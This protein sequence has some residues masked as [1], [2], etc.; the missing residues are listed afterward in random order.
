M[1]VL[2]RL[3]PTRRKNGLQTSGRGIALIAALV[4]SGC[5]TNG[6]VPVVTE[7]DLQADATPATTD[8][9]VAVPPP[10]QDE[11]L[12]RIAESE[13]PK[14][15]KAY[16]G[17]YSDSKLERS[18]ARIVGALT[19]V[20]DN[21]TQSYRITILDSPNINAFALPG[22]YVYVTRGLLALANDSAELAAVISHEMAHVTA[23]H[24]IQRQQK[25]AQ[26]DLGSRVASQVLGDNPTARAALIRGKL[27]LAQF[28]RNQELEADVIGIRAM[29][30]A[31][32]DPFAAPRFLESLN[33]Y[34]TFR[35]A[36]NSEDTKL[37]FLASHPST[38]QRIELARRHARTVGA[39]GV[40]SA[41]RDR[42]LDGIDGMVFGDTPDE[43]FVR[44][45][46]F[47][48]PRL[49]ITFSVPVGF[50][51]DNG[52]EA[53]TATGPG[54]VAVRFDAVDLPQAKSLVGY[55]GSGWVSGLDPASVQTTTVNGLEAVT[56]SARAGGWQFDITV[57]RLADR[58]YRFL[59]A[60]PV[61]GSRL[62]QVATSVR[63][64]FRQLSK[65]E[66]AGLKPLKLQI[67]IVQP[68]DTTVSLAARMQGTDRQLE[69]FQ[70]LNALSR[71]ATVK[72]GDRVKIVT[73]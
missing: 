7:A 20:S 26:A 43:G 19:T 58:A 22:G 61:G 68:G 57:I 67:V 36:E 53:V 9:A 33:R 28:S 71:G 70:I 31:G 14:I 64:S 63:Q 62:P 60:E 55:V 3:C 4:L 41:D 1:I 21:P 46:D 25:Q 42:Y 17:E 2:F 38:P 15:L 40:G 10:A 34:T 65:A 72:A 6:G 27:S 35:D 56:A 48:H 45:T 66:I 24:G 29:G 50:V 8:V 47:L 59:S 69:L 52:K 49:G 54:E 5:L 32:F 51:L 23:N 30:E 39:P 12:R 44:G 13:H 11:A 73:N 37:D 16:G 18:V